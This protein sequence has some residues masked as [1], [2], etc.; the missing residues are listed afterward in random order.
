MFTLLKKTSLV[1]IKKTNF[2]QDKSQDD[3]KKVLFENLKHIYNVSEIQRDL[4]KNENSKEKEVISSNFSSVRLNERPVIESK[5]AS[6]GRNLLLNPQNIN[7]TN[8]MIKDEIRNITGH[9]DFDVNDYIKKKPEGLEN[10]KKLLTTFDKI[11]QGEQPK[12]M[13]LQSFT[14]AHL[15]ELM[16]P[17]VKAVQTTVNQMKKL[18]VKIEKKEAEKENVLENILNKQN[19]IISFMMRQTE[20]KRGKK[21]KLKYKELQQELDKIELG[22]SPDFT[23]F[24]YIYEELNIMLNKE[25]EKESNNNLI[26]LFINIIIAIQTYENLLKQYNEYYTKYHGPTIWYNQMTENYQKT[27]QFL[28][29]INPYKYLEARNKLRIQS[30]NQKKQEKLEKENEKNLQEFII[31]KRFQDQYEKIVKDE[32]K[33]KDSPE[34]KENSLEENSSIKKSAKSNKKNNK[35]LKGDITK[36]KKGSKKK[37]IN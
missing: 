27:M 13:P 5:F 15:E 10:T 12:L 17:V 31:A 36:K 4:A 14:S 25:A 26:T 9:L 24:N 35:K 6:A 20:E 16:V 30:M 11:S 19:E 8:K 2:S 7:E 28:D 37:K 3:K 1:I 33:E 18:D 32:I 21:I 34:L 22:I 29:S 23:K